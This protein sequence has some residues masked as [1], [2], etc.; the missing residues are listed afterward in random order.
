MA[1]QTLLQLINKILSNIGEAQISST[2]GLSGMSLLIFNTLN[3]V[4]YEIFDNPGKYQPCETNCT[5][6]L[7]SNVA[8]YAV[9]T[10]IFDFD[11]DSF[12]YNSEKEIV[13]YTPQRFDREYKKATD[14]NV[15]DKIYQFQG[16]WRPYPIPNTTADGKLITFRAWK[17]PTPYSTATSTGTSIM[18]EGFDITLLADYVTWK[19]MV[20]KENSQAQFYYVKV[21]GDGRNIEG[22][23]DKFISL[24]RSP[25]LS[26]RSI[27]V[28]PMENQRS[29]STPR[30]SQGY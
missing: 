20:Y 16:Y 23:L 30:T 10:D 4:L 29:A 7:T 5:L 19:V 28:E 2:T 13:Y 17:F 26:D 11:R 21:F 3:E 25:D 27:F 18:P 1:K 12:I 22:S 24:Y 15:P 6:T 8:T 14:T 9:A